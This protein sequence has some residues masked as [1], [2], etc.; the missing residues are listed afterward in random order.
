[1][2]RKL[3][4]AGLLT[5]GA[6]AGALTTIQLQAYAR[7]SLAPLPLEE[8]QQLAAVFGMVDRLGMKETDAVPTANLHM[9]LNV[10]ALLVFVV[11]FYLR[12]ASGMHMTG[13]SFK[14]PFVL[15]LIGIILIAISGYLG[16]ELVFRYGVGIEARPEGSPEA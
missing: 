4:V 15:S 6:V 16:G 5:L 9:G 10:V 14:I 7:N 3:K 1:M 13:G 11:S 12:T 8:L 2:G